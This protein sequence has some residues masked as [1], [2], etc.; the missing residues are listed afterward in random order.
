M[1]S[2]WISIS[3]RL[4]LTSR[5]LVDAGVHGLHQRRLAH[6]ARAPQQRV[7]GG[8]AG[9]EALGV[10][11]QDVAHPVDALEQRQLDAADMRHG[12]SA[13]PPGARRRPRR[14]PA[15]WLR[16]LRSRRRAGSRRSPRARLRFADR[17]RRRARSARSTACCAWL[18][19]RSSSGGLFGGLARGLAGHLMLPS[20]API[21]G[22]CE[23]GKRP[24][25][26]GLSRRCNW[27]RGGYSPR[28]F[29]SNQPIWLLAKP[30][31][32]SQARSLKPGFFKDAPC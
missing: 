4:P 18:G 5:P 1:S 11:G 13:G 32:V 30:R 28:E 24:K 12:D 17:R 19:R 9:G 7:V 16:P 22:P 20:A 14:R 31:Q 21:T 27:D 15:D 6:A 2:R 29:W 8:Q 10:L 25:N 23:V 26:Q 3:F